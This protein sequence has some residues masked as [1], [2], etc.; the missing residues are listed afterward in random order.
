MSG[1]PAVQAR[2]KFLEAAG[3][4]EESW[5]CGDRLLDLFTT[6]VL[7]KG[8]DC[9]SDDIAHA[10]AIAQERVDPGFRLPWGTLTQ[11]TPRTADYFA[12][13]YR[14]AV[15]VAGTE[16]AIPGAVP[17]SEWSRRLSQDVPDG[18]P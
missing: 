8:A 1:N 13:H 11:E 10:W 5:T 17:A 15:R 7:V 2:I 9:T 6:L 16:M 12:N 14:N 4:T 3:E 18:A